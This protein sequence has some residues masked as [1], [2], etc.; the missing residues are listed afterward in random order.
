MHVF[1]PYLGNFVNQKPSTT[2]T[3]PLLEGVSDLYNGNKTH[4]RSMYKRIH[5]IVIHLVLFEVVDQ[6]VIPFRKL[7]E[8][9]VKI[10]NTLARERERES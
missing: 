5:L 6:L 9:P 8:M 7:Q 2:K 1:K 3:E 10:C 4:Y